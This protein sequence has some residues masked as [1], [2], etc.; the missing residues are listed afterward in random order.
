MI[1]HRAALAFVHWCVDTFGL[2]GDDRVAAVAAL[3]F[4]LS[5]FDL[6]ATVAVGA[7]YHP[8][9]PFAFLRPS[10]A[11]QWIEDE[12]L[13][14][15]GTRHPRPFVCCSTGATWKT[16]RPAP[17]GGCCLPARVFP[18]PALRRLRACVTRGSALQPLTA[19]PR[20]TSARFTGSTRCPT[21]DPICPWAAPVPDPRS[22]SSMRRGSPPRT[23]RSARLWVRGPT[24]MDGYWG[25]PEATA[26]V[27]GPHPSRPSEEG[28]WLRTGD[29]A[30]RD[31]E[32]RLH[33]HGRRDHMVKVRGYR[34]E[35]GE[36]EAALAAHPDLEAAVVIPVEVAERS[37]VRLRAWVVPRQAPGIDPRPQAL[38]RGSAPALYDSGG[39]SLPGRSSRDLDGQGRPSC[40]GGK[41]RLIPERAPAR[42]LR[43]ARVGFRAQRRT[44]T[45]ARHVARSREQSQRRPGRAR[46]ARS[47]SAPGVG[48]LW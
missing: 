39:V 35:L 34:V 12:A 5:I 36:V 20:A 43:G 1:S 32:G 25:S 26:K 31:A 27:L 48:S 18:T 11:R 23:V 22:R 24:L 40:P 46:P 38:P 19:R 14:R 7:S 30:H 17:F 41:H 44:T 33:F 4:D 6:F 21:T 2:R 45:V 29:L 8:L 15:S 37:E 13:D 9:P 28:P 16:D 42:R 3:H 10:E 47:L